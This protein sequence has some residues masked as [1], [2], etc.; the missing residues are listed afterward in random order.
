MAVMATIAGRATTATVGY[1]Q[2]FWISATALT[3][4][5]ALALTLPGQP[6]SERHIIS[7]EEI[8]EPA[9]LIET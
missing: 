5:A 9:V 8:A 2:A 4:G 3:I 7:R 6:K 1:D